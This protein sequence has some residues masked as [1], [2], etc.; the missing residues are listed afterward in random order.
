MLEFDGQ[1]NCDHFEPVLHP[2]TKP[3]PSPPPRRGSPRCMPTR[4]VVAGVRFRVPSGETAF[5]NSDRKRKKR[6]LANQDVTDCLPKLFEQTI[7]AVP[8]NNNINNKMSAIFQKSGKSI[9]KKRKVKKQTKEK[10]NQN[11]QTNKQKSNN[12]KQKQTNPTHPPPPKKNNPKAE[13]RRKAE[14]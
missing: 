11:K 12:K 9:L 4:S 5:S 10:P 7:V 14:D 13:F 8:V 2:A 3:S 6:T 1:N